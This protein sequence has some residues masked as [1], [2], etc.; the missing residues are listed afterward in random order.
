MCEHVCVDRV[1]CNFV[2]EEGTLSAITTR[3]MNETYRNMTYQIGERRV[4]VRDALRERDGK[5]RFSVCRAGA[6]AVHHRRVVVARKRQAV[7]RSLQ[8]IT[9]AV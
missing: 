6:G 1:Y 9:V 4:G 3:R 7:N 5:G 8:V 2:D